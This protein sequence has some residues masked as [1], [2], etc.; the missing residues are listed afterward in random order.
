VGAPRGG[1]RGGRGQPP[2][3]ADHVHLSSSGAG[4]PVVVRQGGCFLSGVVASPSWADSAVSSVTPVVDPSM[5]VDPTPGVGR[6]S[7][8]SRGRGVGVRHRGAPPLPAGRLRFYPLAFQAA[9]DPRPSHSLGS[10]SFWGN[11]SGPAPVC[12]ARPPGHTRPARFTT[13]RWSGRVPGGGPARA[14]AGCVGGPAG[15]VR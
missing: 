4:P 9:S 15:G 13:P 10:Y 14:G 8:P 5:G 12:L 7:R 1:V 6:T 2:S 11:P 3:P